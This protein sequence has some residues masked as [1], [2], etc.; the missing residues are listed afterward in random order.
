MTVNNEEREIETV[1]EMLKR[2][3]DEA[4][5]HNID[6]LRIFSMGMEAQELIEKKTAERLVAERLEAEKINSATD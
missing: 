1:S 5:D 3:L 6:P 2:R 4:K